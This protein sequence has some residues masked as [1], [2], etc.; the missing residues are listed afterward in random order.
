M[1]TR[2]EVNKLESNWLSDSCWDIENTEGF[3]EYYEELFNFRIAWEKHWTQA[4]HERI[5]EQMEE[6]GLE[7]NTKLFDHL[8]RLEERIEELEKKYSQKFNSR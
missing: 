7:G 6:M 4:R 1:K 8:V 2:A 5:V 3:E